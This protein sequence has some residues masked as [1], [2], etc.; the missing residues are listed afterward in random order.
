MEYRVFKRKIY[1]KM[2]PII[3]YPKD[4]KNEGELLYLPVYMT[5]LL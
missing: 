2:R 3:L 4:L 1:D 5:P